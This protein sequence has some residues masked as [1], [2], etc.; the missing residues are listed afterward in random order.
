MVMVNVQP[1]CEQR[2]VLSAAGALALLRVIELL[3]VSISKSVVFPEIALEVYLGSTAV[4]EWP[5]IKLTVLYELLIL[6]LR[7]I[8]STNLAYLLLKLGVHFHSFAKSV[9][10]SWWLIF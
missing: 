9:R 4:A 10:H 7:F 1:I 5:A 8:Y 3:V 6:G 2:F